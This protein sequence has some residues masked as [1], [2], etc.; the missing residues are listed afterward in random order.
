MEEKTELLGVRIDCI[1]AKEAMQRA[2]QFLADDTLDTIDLVSMSMLLKGQEHPEWREKTEEIKLILPVEEE[3]LKAAG[4]TEP[5]KLK[6][7]REHTFLKMFLKYMQKS[8][9]SVFFLTESEEDY[10]TVRD[11]VK[12]YNRGIRITGHALLAAD[13]AKEESVINQINGTET[14]C[15]VSLLSSPYQE[16]FIAKNKALINAKM[17]LGCGITLAQSYEEMKFFKRLRHFWLSRLFR[18]SVGRHQADQTEEYQ[19][20]VEMTGE[21]IQNLEFERD[22]DSFV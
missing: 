4:V 18:Y 9:K 15:V 2:L 3:I 12:K 5:I 22:K 10:L 19:D 21:D 1:R 8:R 17:W 7:T 11:A 6:E 13:G 14:D 16:A 20:H